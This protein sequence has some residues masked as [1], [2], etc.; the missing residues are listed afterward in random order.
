MCNFEIPQMLGNGKEQMSASNSIAN[1]IQTRV[2]E[3][4]GL[5]N[6]IVLLTYFILRSVWLFYCQD[7]R[8]FYYSSC[9]NKQYLNQI[10]KTNVAG[11]KA[12]LAL[13]PV[14]SFH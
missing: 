6:D 9:Y 4:V 14:M 2:I 11:F 7:L 8:S 5:L 13:K 1:M 3:L 10:N 12:T